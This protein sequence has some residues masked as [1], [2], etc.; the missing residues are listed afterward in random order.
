M[1]MREPW[2]PGET[3]EE[4]AARREAYARLSAAARRVGL[5]LERLGGL[6]RQVA[7][8]EAETRRFLSDEVY[9][10]PDDALDDLLRVRLEDLARGGDAP[11]AG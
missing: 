3:P 2:Q 1:S 11:P 5:P 6:L 9:G 10:V 4:Q 8:N 7:H